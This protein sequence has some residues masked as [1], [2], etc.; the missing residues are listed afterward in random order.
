M[1]KRAGNGCK[2]ADIEKIATMDWKRLEMV[3]IGWTWQEMGMGELNWQEI[4]RNDWQWL[5]MAGYG[6]I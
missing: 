2:L 1:L 3:N 4:A 5:E 6:R